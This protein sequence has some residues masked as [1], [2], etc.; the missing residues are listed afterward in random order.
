MVK[1]CTVPGP[2]RRG[3]A[4]A[5]RVAAVVGVA[6]AGV[7]AGDVA[8]VPAAAGE[9]GAVVEAV[10]LAGGCPARAPDVT[11]GRAASSPA[12]TGPTTARTAAVTI[13]ATTQA[14]GPFRTNRKLWPNDPPPSHHPV[15][16]ITG[17]GRDRRRPLRRAGR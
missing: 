5:G 16:T 12:S 9:D 14:R 13:A 2:G 17:S 10:A 1:Y 11:A 4:A 6:L 8:A 7:V 15:A 3:R